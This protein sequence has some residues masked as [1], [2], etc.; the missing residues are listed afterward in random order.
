MTLATHSAGVRSTGF[1][2]DWRSRKLIGVARLTALAYCIGVVCLIDTMLLFPSP[3]HRQT[4]RLKGIMASPASRSLTSAS[5]AAPMHQLTQGCCLHFLCTDKCIGPKGIMAGSTRILVTH[6]RQYLPQCDRVAVLRGGRLV[7]LG[8]YQEIAQLQLPELLAG[9]AGVSLDQAGSADL[10]G[11]HGCSSSS[12]S[13]GS[14]GPAQPLAAQTAEAASASAAADRDSSTAAALD[15]PAPGVNVHDLEGETAAAAAAHGNA[16]QASSSHSSEDAPSSGTD[17]IALVIPDAPHAEALPPAD[18]LPPKRLTWQEP[19]ADTSHAPATSTSIKAPA[20]LRHD[21][22]PHSTTTSSKDVSVAFAEE[23]DAA[24]PG[25]ILS[26]DRTLAPDVNYRPPSFG[27][28]QQQ[29]PR[30]RGLRMLSGVVARRVGS[31][32]GGLRGRLGGWG[33]SF[34]GAVAKEEAG[35]ETAKE[36]GGVG[37]ASCCSWLYFHHRQIA[38]GARADTARGAAPPTCVFLST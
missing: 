30:P 19:A 11:V 17:A 21:P 4:H 34:V 5:R 20:E 7:A 25:P 18:T 8:S 14:S 29:Q 23:A 6:Q 38:S 35:G 31:G 2:I 1:C 24:D 32:I 12:N 33:A 15:V 28:M 26:R 22:A 13:S 9:G 16:Q 10:D 3:L 27:A 37:G 36:V